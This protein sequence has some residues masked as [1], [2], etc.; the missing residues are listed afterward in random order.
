MLLFSFLHESNHA[1]P[2]AGPKGPLQ[3]GQVNP[4]AVHVNSLKNLIINPFYSFG[5]GVG[6]WDLIYRG[7]KTKDKIIFTRI[8][9]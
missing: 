6:N 1:Q 8:I 2:H 7:H 5:G 3:D 4:Q 9:E